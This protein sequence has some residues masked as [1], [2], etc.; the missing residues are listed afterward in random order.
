MTSMTFTAGTIGGN[1][2]TQESRLV[3]GKPRT[4]GRSDVEAER[5][6]IVHDGGDTVATAQETRRSVGPVAFSR[7]AGIPVVIRCRGVLH[8]DL[9]KPGI[10]PWRL[11]KM[12]VDTDV[13]HG[14]KEYRFQAEGCRGEGDEYRY[15]L[16]KIAAQ[17]SKILPRISGVNIE[18]GTVSSHDPV[19][20]AVIC[21]ALSRSHRCFVLVKLMKQQAVLTPCRTKG[22]LLTEPTA[23]AH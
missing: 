19:I 1:D 10:F 17:H 18:K 20:V 16:A 14:T 7:N 2:L 4:Q 5:G 6:V 21:E 23:L 15:R 13:T 12:T 3:M 8:L 22:L 11:I 9:L